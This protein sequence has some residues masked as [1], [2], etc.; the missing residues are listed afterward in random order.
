MAR[1][2]MAAVAL[3]ALLLPMVAD[4]APRL[5]DPMFADH[6]VVQRDRSVAVWGEAAPGAGVDVMLGPAHATAKA[7]VDGLWRATLPALKAGGPYALTAVSGADT[8]TVQ[9]VM[10]GDVFLCSG[11]SN[12]ELPVV[13]SVNGK[14]AIAQ[15]ADDGIRLL[16][17]PQFYSAV[18]LA[19]LPEP[20]DW[21]TAGP[22][23]VGDFSAVCFF[24]AQALRQT[25]K[26]VPLGLIDNSWGGS[27]ISAW[28]NSDSYIAS[29]GDPKTAALVTLFAN[30]PLAAN[31][32][33]GDV[34]QTWWQEHEKN[35]AEAAPWAADFRPDA[36]WKQVPALDHWAT[37]HLSELDNFVGLM[38]YRT[39]VTLTPAQAAEGATLLLG[40]VDDL[41]QTWIN[42]HPVGTGWGAPLRRYPIAPGML[43]A[44]DNA[45]VVNDFNAWADGGIYGPADTRAIAFADG[46]SVPLSGPWLY[47]TVTEF[48]DQPPRAPWDAIAGVG[49]IQNGMVAPLGAYGIKGVAWYQG[50]SDAPLR[51]GYAP[52]LQAL[53]GQWRSAFGKHLP[54]AV[55]QL[56]NFGPKTTA[57]VDSD[58][59]S[60]REAQ[61]RAVAD[62]PDAA[63]VVTIDLGDAG[64]LHPPN[65]RPV[66]AR[67]AAAMDHI[68]Y[69]NPAPASGP[70]P[71]AAKRNG[72][73][74][75]VA[76]ANVDGK[77]RAGDAAPFELCGDATASCHVVPGRADG[78]RAVLPADPA[79][80]RVRYCWADSPI[81]TIRDATL[82]ATPFELP[83]Q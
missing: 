9:D 13:A 39:T 19:R 28:L 35:P 76:F 51:L 33:W 52:R 61:R 8:L 83:V 6:A 16:T 48:H 32:Q 36:R 26:N 21:K 22:D 10:A 56:P 38:W 43:V 81:C 37:W 14:D 20:A 17:I 80:T 27:A 65:K 30:D 67:L 78:V 79:A 70:T 29:G 63:L 15:S 3:S 77:L 46:S 58:W 54:V 4:G 66:G 7:G 47:R 31:R 74:I 24:M 45:I 18:P 71:I 12:M 75:L 2:L 57:P 60:L 69:G 73:R 68:A 41:D 59:A 49:T 42:G 50:E 5:L 82:P 72:D 62:D 44:G 64:N 34:W 40:P 55:I 1:S 25:H 53:I 11:Q 23:S